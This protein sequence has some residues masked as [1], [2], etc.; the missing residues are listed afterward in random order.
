MQEE[1]SVY[2]DDD[3]QMGIISVTLSLKLFALFI[4]AW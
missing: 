4:Q 1:H 3:S 2:L